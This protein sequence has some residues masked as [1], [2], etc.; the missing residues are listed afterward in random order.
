MTYEY[1]L[2][3][4]QKP[5]RIAHRSCYILTSLL[6][7]AFGNGEI[8]VDTSAIADFDGADIEFSS[9][10]NVHLPLPAAYSDWVAFYGL[11]DGEHLRK[12]M[13]RSGIVLM[14]QMHYDD[15]AI[16]AFSVTTIIV[17]GM[18]GGPTGYCVIFDEGNVLRA[19]QPIC[20]QSR[21]S[22]IE[23]WI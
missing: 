15:A 13:D 22:R 12:R 19:S 16:V 5:M 21:P 23:F 1:G 10:T 17:K 20:N 8:E 11:D 7:V 14:S 6:A 9:C 2:H 4:Q 18:R 3:V